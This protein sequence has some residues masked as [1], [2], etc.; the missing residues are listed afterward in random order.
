MI[1]IYSVV[2]LVK[3]SSFTPVKSRNGILPVSFFLFLFIFLRG[4]EPQKTRARA[5]PI[6]F[7]LVNA[8]CTNLYINQILCLR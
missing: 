7:P 3:P 6:F 2:R 1:C 8:G 5:N 4:K